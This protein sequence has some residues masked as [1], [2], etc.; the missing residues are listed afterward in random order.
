MSK[1]VQIIPTVETLYSIKPV[2]LNGEL[3]NEHCVD[4]VHYLALLDD[5]SVRGLVNFL[6]FTTYESE[7]L[8][9]TMD[10]AAWKEKVQNDGDI[11][12]ER[13]ESDN[14]DIKDLP[15]YDEH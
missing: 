14:M 12:H 5:G 1:I 3:T 15:F 7:D 9:D 10:Y 2:S 13:F 8:L 11:V 4:K 6:K